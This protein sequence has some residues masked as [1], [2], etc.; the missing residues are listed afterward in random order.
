VPMGMWSLEL[1][2]ICGGEAAGDHAADQKDKADDG[3][4]GLNITDERSE[5]HVDEEIFRK[6]LA[7]AHVDL[8]FH[9]RLKE[10]G[11]VHVRGQQI[12]SIST[13]DGRQWTAKIFADCSYE[14]DLMA[15]AGVKYTYGRESRDQYGESL[16][17]V[18]DKTLSPEP[19]GASGP[20]LI[21][22]SR[23]L[24]SSQ[25]ESGQENW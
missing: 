6:M 16:A 1:A 9:E 17:G 14:G 11:G 25:A 8:R 20:G 10:H 21:S 2:E 7:D 4:D 15:E 22:G 18:R 12:R 13:M 24:R 5:P 19:A 3:E 23:R